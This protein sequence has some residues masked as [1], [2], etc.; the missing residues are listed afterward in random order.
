MVSCSN[1]AVTLA[2]VTTAVYTSLTI[3]SWEWKRLGKTQ[4][5]LDE[6]DV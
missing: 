2:V 1:A 4:E 6:R 5:D 3:Y